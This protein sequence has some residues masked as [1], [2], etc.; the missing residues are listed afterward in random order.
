MSRFRRVLVANRGEIALRVIRGAGAAGYETVA[1][2]SDADA[3]APH[4]RAADTAVRL[5]PAAPV[6]SYLHTGRI[7]DAAR[8][9]GA[10]AIHPG[11]GFLSERAAFARAVTDAGLVFIGPSAEAIEAMGDKAAA[12]QRMQAAGVPCIPGHSGAQ[13]DDQLLVEARRV[14]YPI[15]VKASAGG[16]GRG[17][18][19][20]RG[21]DELPDSLR[22]ARSEAELAFGDGTLLL[23][24]ALF[25]ARHVEVQV[26][27]DQHGHVV[28]LG[29]RDCSVQRRNQKLVEEAPGPSVTAALRRKLG[30]AA[31][32]AAQA[33]RYVGAGTVEMMLVDATGEFFFLEMNTR[34]QV[35]H[36]VTELVYGVDLV[37]LQLS[38]AQ[39][40]PLPWSQAEIDARRTGHAI[41]VRLCAEDAQMRPRTGTVLRWSPPEGVR[42]DAGIETGSVVGSS[43]DSLL[44]KL[45]AHGPDRET[46]RR[47]LVEAL[48]RTT[49]LGVETN[50]ALLLAIIEGD[51]FSSGVFDTRLLDTMPLPVVPTWHPALAAIVLE[52]AGRRALSRHSTVVG[53]ES[54]RLAARAFALSCDDELVRVSLQALDGD[55]WRAGE[56]E[57][58]VRAFSETTLR[59]TIDGLERSA[60]WTLDGD[61]LWLDAAG[62]TRVYVDRTY[63]PSIGTR[64]PT[65]GLVRA[66]FDGRV[67]RVLV[68]VGQHAEAGQPLCVLESM[69]LEHTLNAS[70]AGQVTAVHVAPGDQVV[71]KRVIIELAAAPSSS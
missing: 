28:H 41:E 49:L 38:V 5:G 16:G 23:E 62:V 48:R 15:M 30:E 47:R 55:R 44:G 1:V 9:S 61:T 70:A 54:T 17:M 42:V 59:Y 11:Y 14:G 68:T 6:E 19:L 7:L 64:G 27:G 37:G 12:K 71:A 43:Y 66:P 67:T 33:V 52:L 18:R 10:Q 24:K 4:V 21:E 39:G 69:K 26:L 45:I 31:V 3:D 32:R 56:H 65:D 8:R 13:S 22:S 36:P 25:G 2:Y 63:A 58:Q 29:E 35:E 57:L 20:V 53:W 34:L 60:A 40:D 50:R 51:A 46:A